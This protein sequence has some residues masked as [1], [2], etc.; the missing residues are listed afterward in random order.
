MA[1]MSPR[2]P[3]SQAWFRATAVGSAP[4]GEPQLWQDPQGSMDQAAVA[5]TEFSCQVRNN[6]PVAHAY[7]A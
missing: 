6:W 3:L 2:L 7:S 1:N 5:A 4:Q